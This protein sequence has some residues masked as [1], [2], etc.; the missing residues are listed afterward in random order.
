[1]D[2]NP[3]LPFASHGCTPSSTRGDAT[4]PTG[5]QEDDRR[6]KNRL[7]KLSDTCL[8]RSPKSA[9]RFRALRRVGALAYTATAL[10]WQGCTHFWGPWDE[11]KRN[12]DESPHNSSETHPV[13]F[14]KTPFSLQTKRTCIGH[15]FHLSRSS[16]W[17][18][19]FL[20]P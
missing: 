1:M 12:E 13:V 15:D 11:A 8:H 9:G 3:P 18:M 10:P 16:R 14:E 20:N 2:D 7:F 19:P 4:T 17:M 6:R 5:R